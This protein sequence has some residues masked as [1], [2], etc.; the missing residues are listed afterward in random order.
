MTSYEHWIGRRVRKNSG[1][2]FRSGKKI[3]TVTAIIEHPQRRGKPAF[4]L[5]DGAYV[6]CEQCHAIW[7]DVIN[8]SEDFRTL[9][10]DLNEAGITHRFTE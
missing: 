3:E 8:V 2:P 4:V 7:T 10:T 9:V 5:G 1:K 6:S